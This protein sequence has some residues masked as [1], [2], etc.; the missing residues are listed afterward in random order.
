M[1]KT[2]LCKCISILLLCVVISIVSIKSFGYEVASENKF[3]VGDLIE[4]GSYP[5]SKVTDPHI[6]YEFNHRDL[7]WKSYGYYS[8]QESGDWMQYADSVYQG[9]KYRAVRFY[10]YRPNYTSNPCISSNLAK[11]DNTYQDDNQYYND[12]VYYFKYEP[13]VWRILD[14]EVGLV[15]CEK[16]IDS[17]AYN[18]LYYFGG[19]EPYSDNKRNYGYWN[20]SDRSVYANNYEKSSIRIWLQNNFYN[21]AFNAKQQDSILPTV[22]DNSAYSA[23]RSK[24]DSV[25]TFDKIFLLSEKESQN[26]SYSFSTSEN[27]LVTCSDY[28]NCNGAYP[29]WLL[30]TA[31]GGSNGVRCVDN[32]GDASSVNTNATYSGIR[33]ALRLSSL[34]TDSLQLY[35]IKWKS[36]GEIYLSEDVKTGDAI[37]LP[38]PP[39]REG[40][41]FKCWSPSV[42]EIM[43]S[44]DLVFDAVFEPNKYNATLLADGKV[45]KSIEYLYGQESIDLPPVP[46][47]EGYT[48]KWEDYTLTAGGVTINAVYTVNSYTVK[49]VV[50]GNETVENY[51]FGS[52][53]NK[54]A[55][56]ELYGHVFN[57]WSPEVPETMPAQDMTFTAVFEPIKTK[58]SINTPSVTTVSYGFTL[59]LHA[60]VTDLPEG[61]G[62]VWSMD[63]SGFELIPSA[64]GMT[65]G[66]KSVSKGSA[67]ITARVVDKNGNAV[68]DANGNEIT[69]SQQLTSKAGFF[70]KL[71]AFFKKLFG[72]NMVIP[73]S[74]NKLIK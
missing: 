26:T 62:V 71:A 8:N 46:E 52:K 1:R 27:R 45:H 15:I 30:R 43:P 17:Q 61:A 10:K 53:I 13:L 32:H 35:N 3:N 68:K 23:E 41:T 4:F 42:P 49:W 70:Q 38:T 48:G 36:E 60:N 67:T 40:Y 22:I 44:N 16:V 51:D 29:I 66:V 6:I 63:G 19:Q 12:R 31:S 2:K 47:K 74:L 54:H 9:V 57:G 72:S 59:N 33:P 58:I 39:A 21:T 18:D 73:S 55:D 24:F 64:D 65:C 20:N 14:P 56:P 7:D 37:N 5:Q 69:A 25:P 28:A 50:N 34:N 11:V